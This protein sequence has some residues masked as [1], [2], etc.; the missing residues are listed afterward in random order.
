MECK[1]KKE[2]RRDVKNLKNRL[3]RIAGQINGV[4]KM[5]DENR[6]CGDVLIQ[7]SAIETALENLGYI[8][9]QEHLETCVVDDVKNDKT[10]MDEVIALMKR[11][12]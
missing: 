8:I 5:I 9:L 7:I 11:L 4:E 6:Y 1:C 12:K 10:N 3:H 2:P